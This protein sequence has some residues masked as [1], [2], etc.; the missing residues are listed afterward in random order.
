MAGLRRAGR[1]QAEADGTY[2][3]SSPKRPAT[4]RIAQVLRGGL[5]GMLI[6]ARDD[7]FLPERFLPLTG[8]QEELVVRELP[9]EPGAV[10]TD[11]LWHVRHDRSAAHQW[12]LARFA[13]VAS[14]LQAPGAPA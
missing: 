1:D 9:V 3:Y 11:A 8:L 5:T 7:P 10:Y 4:F 14:P 13:E 2:F 6:N 12:L